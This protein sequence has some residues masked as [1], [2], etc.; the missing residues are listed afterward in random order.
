MKLT[1]IYR[2]GGNPI[3]M[4]DSEG[5]YLELHCPRAGGRRHRHAS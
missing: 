1:K 5:K 2:M 4:F 3:Y